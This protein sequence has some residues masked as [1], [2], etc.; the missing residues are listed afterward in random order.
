MFGAF[1]A[2]ACAATVA[3]AKRNNAH[4]ERG[5]RNLPFNITADEMFDIFG[6]YGAIRQIRM[7][8]QS[9]RCT[10]TRCLFLT[11]AALLH[12]GSTKDTRGTAYVVYEDIYDAK[13]AADHLSGFNVA[14]RYLI[15]LYFQPAKQAKK[16]DQTKQEEELAALQRMRSGA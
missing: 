6:K 4:A 3:L 13:A 12:R 15:V 7:Y 11:A 10:A 16:L 1:G 14:N 5:H 2:A 8:V 9:A